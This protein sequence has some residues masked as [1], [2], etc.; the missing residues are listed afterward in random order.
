MAIYQGLGTY[1]SSLQAQG[2]VLKYEQ[3]RGDAFQCQV[4][5]SQCLDVMLRLHLW[6][7]SGE[8]VPA[9]Q[10]RL[11]G[12]I[13]AY[14]F[15][16]PERLGLSDGQVFLESGRRLDALKANKK[17][18]LN[19]SLF[20]QD[21]RSQLVADMLMPLIGVC[22]S[23]LTKV[24]SRI[25]LH[26]LDGKTQVELAKLLGMQQSAISRHIKAMHATQLQKSF[27]SWREY[28]GQDMG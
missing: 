28:V 22:L 1:L 23:D 6:L 8:Q 4:S 21:A 7:G 3:Y 12:A 25:M 11:S 24:R 13:G 19:M 15:V 27:R 20:Y 5:P 9:V 16:H 10:V 14:D 26:W 18:G 17:D 2:L